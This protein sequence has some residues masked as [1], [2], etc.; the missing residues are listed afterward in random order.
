M[1]DELETLFRMHACGTLLN[2]LNQ[3]ECTYESGSFWI[4]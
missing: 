2:H 3:L 4:T 1:H